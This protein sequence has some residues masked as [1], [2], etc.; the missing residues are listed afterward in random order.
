MANYFSFFLTFATLLSGLAWLLDRRLCKIAVGAIKRPEEEERGTDGTEQPRMKGEGCASWFS[1]LASMFPVVATVLFV[2]S[3]L[4]EPYQ[5]PSGSMMPTLL[6]G[7]FILVNKYAY[8][9]KDP[10]FQ[11][12]LLATGRPQRGDVAVF[13]YPED[14]KTYFIK[15]IVGLPG[16][17]IIY[18]GKRLFILPSPA[19]AGADITPYPVTYSEI[20]SSDE[21]SDGQEQNELSEKLGAVSHHILLNPSL[22]D[23]PFYYQQPG[24][25]FAEWVVPEGHY[26]ALG[27]NRDNSR[28]SRFWGFVP[29]QNLVGRAGAIWMSFKKQPGGWPTGIRLRRVGKI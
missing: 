10:L 24:E 25:P 18:R 6:V 2:R 22:P 13:K 16:D 5:I 3:F 20:G 8:G 9:L 23:S 7:D 26:F 14:P 17:R 21:A 15:R 1:F 29:E 28:D 11:H 19:H 4:Y 12:Q 27:D